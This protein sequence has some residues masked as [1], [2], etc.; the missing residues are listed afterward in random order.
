[1]EACLSSF[2]CC[3]LPVDRSN[4]SFQFV[5]RLS[6][7]VTFSPSIS[8][9]NS[10][11]LSISFWVVTPLHFH[12]KNPDVIL[13]RMS[14]QDKC[15]NA[16]LSVRFPTTANWRNSPWGAVKHAPFR[17]LWVNY[18][19]MQIYNVFLW[20]WGALCNEMWSQHISHKDSSAPLH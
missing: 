13:S 3:L 15:L 2:T 20:V 16:T 7:L 19:F 5:G 14:P 12:W 4:W 11:E 18:L 10:G 6:F 17:P 1:M 8:L 9:S